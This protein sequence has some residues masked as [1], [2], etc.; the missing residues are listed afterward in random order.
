MKQLHKL[1]NGKV[2]MT[3]DPDKHIYEVDGKIVE[4]VT[5]V[6]S[7]ISKPALMYWA[8]NMAIEYMQKHLK[9]GESYDEIEIKKILE[10]AKSAHRTKKEDAGDIGTLVHEAIEQYIKTGKEEAPVH[11]KAKVCFEN[12]IK[13]VKDKKVIFTESE[14]KIYSQ[15]LRYAG[16]M[17][18]VCK[19]GGMTFVGDI[20]TA[21]GV[22]DE[23]W[24]QCSGYQQAYEEETGIK[25]DGQI[26]VRVGKTGDFEA[27]ENYEYE[28]NVEAFNGALKLYRRV[29]N[30][31]DKKEVKAN[32]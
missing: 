15:R 14:R 5:G 30:L 3:F 4:G 24:F 2:E 13:W 8:V 26:I 19:I 1:Y 12:F 22:Y 16:T 28:E 20:K 9:A 32:E 27:P 25:I 6:I 17:D 10:G 31:R 7:V 23:M 21:S 11:E 18:F 29:Q